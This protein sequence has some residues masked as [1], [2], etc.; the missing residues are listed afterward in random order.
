MGG[1]AQRN[2]SP[3]QKE[4]AQTKKKIKGYNRLR[5]R[6]APLTFFSACAMKNA[7]TGNIPPSHFYHFGPS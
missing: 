3:P 1:A 5:R 6:F 7:A 2:I 4:K